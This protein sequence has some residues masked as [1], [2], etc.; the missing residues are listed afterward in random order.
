[1]LTLLYDKTFPPRPS[2]AKLGVKNAFN[3]TS[4]QFIDKDD[5]RQFNYYGHV[6]SGELGDQE[7]EEDVQKL[8]AEIEEVMKGAATRKSEV[9]KQNIVNLQG[10]YF[11][12]EN[13]TN[14]RG[15]VEQTQLNAEYIY[16]DQDF[17]DQN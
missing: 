9:S 11:Q 13:I 7:E 12:K 16:E 2:T 5:M 1:M 15:G 14:N 6:G 8:E 17:S 10:N 3:Q 4:A